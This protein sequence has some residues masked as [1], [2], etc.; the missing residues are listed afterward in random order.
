VERVNQYVQPLKLK[1]NILINLIVN[2]LG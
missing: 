2:G 1:V